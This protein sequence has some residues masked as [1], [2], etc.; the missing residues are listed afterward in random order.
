MQSVALRFLNDADTLDV[1]S[2]VLNGIVNVCQ[3]MH[4]SV[5]K[6]SDRF[7]QQL[8][9]HNYV[10]PTSYLELLS[11]YTELVDKKKNELI[12]G[13]LRLRSG[14]DKLLTTAEEVKDLQVQLESLKPIL[15][16]AA[17]EA[18]IMIVQIAK[19]QVSYLCVTI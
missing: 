6:A 5:V 10:T 1:D 9:R 12:L 13:I 16:V 8:N 11:S 17:K 2:I 3:F 15:A 18:E 7:L 14:L 19:D 4:A